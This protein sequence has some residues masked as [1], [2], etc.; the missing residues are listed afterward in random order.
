MEY[1]V[2]NNH[3]GKAVKTFENLEEAINWCDKHMTKYGNRVTHIENGQLV[4]DYDN[5]KSAMERTNAK[6]A[7]KIKRGGCL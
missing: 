3:N 4:T 1:K 7:A 5:A 6:N 2:R